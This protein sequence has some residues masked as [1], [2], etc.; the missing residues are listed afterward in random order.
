MRIAPRPIMQKKGKAKKNPKW[1]A[2]VAQLPCVICA[3]W[4][5]QVHHCIHDRFSQRRSP[6]TETIPLCFECH[7]RLHDNKREWREAHG[8]DYSYLDLVQ[9][10]IK[11]LS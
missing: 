6:D 9:T 10:L 8:P 4:P 11:A 2:K 7:N 1:M 5:V 3:K